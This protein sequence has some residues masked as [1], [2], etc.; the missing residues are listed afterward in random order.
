MDEQEQS[1]DP[2]WTPNNWDETRKYRAKLLTA[3]GSILAGFEEDWKAL[4]EILMVVNRED[5]EKTATTPLSAFLFHIDCGIYPPPEI[6]MTIAACFKRYS[7][8][9]GDL[10]LEDCFFGSPGKGKSIYSKRRSREKPFESF[11]FYVRL[12]LL[13]EH[14]GKRDKMSIESIA[15][16]FFHDPDNIIGRY[17][18]DIDIDTFLRGYRR[19]KEKILSGQNS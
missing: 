15:E 13:G 5:D 3:E 11:Q 18:P 17:E 7:E 1:L 9:G 19:W 6:L 10:T 2:N 16:E 8:A 14:V 12:C 4:E